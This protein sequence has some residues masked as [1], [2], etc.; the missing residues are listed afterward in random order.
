MVS[1]FVYLV[2]PVLYPYVFAMTLTHTSIISIVFEFINI[3]NNVIVNIISDCAILII[4][5]SIGIMILALMLNSNI[6]LKTSKKLQRVTQQEQTQMAM[7]EKFQTLPINHNDNK[8]N[9]SHYSLDPINAV[10]PGIK[11]YDVIG[12]DLQQNVLIVMLFYAFD[13]LHTGFEKESE[14]QCEFKN[15]NVDCVDLITE[16]SLD[17]GFDCDATS[18]IESSS[19]VLSL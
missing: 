19:F 6:I 5:R 1:V 12:Y 11:A 15:K 10:T 4:I 17:K 9:S 14:S 13:S 3:R 2:H 16:Y 18:P 7:Q 8:V